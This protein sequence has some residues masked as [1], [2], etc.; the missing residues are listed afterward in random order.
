MAQNKILIFEK[1]QKPKAILEKVLKK[2][3]DLDFAD[4][5]DLDEKIEHNK[6]VL[7]VVDYQDNG[8]TLLKKIKLKEPALKVLVLSKEQN[9]AEVIMT[10]KMGGTYFLSKPLSEDALR[11][12]VHQILE[13][14]TFEMLDVSGDYPWYLS[15]HTKVEELLKMAKNVALHSMDVIL[16]GEQGTGKEALANFIHQNGPS[17]SRQFASLNL[18]YF[19]GEAIETHFWASLREIYQEYDNNA[20]GQKEPIYS[21]LFVQGIE[22][23]DV[24]FRMS[25]IEWLKQKRVEAE[26]KY[27]MPIRIVLAVNSP[28]VLKEIK[29]EALKSFVW[30][31]LLPLRERREDIPLFVDHLI[32]KYDMQFNKNIKGFTLDALKKLMLYSWPGNLREL[33]LMI[34]VVLSRIPENATQISSGDL[35]ITFSFLEEIIPVKKFS[36]VVPLA[37][38]SEEYESKLLK[39][40]YE[41]KEFDTNGVA[42]FLSDSP[43]EIDD[44]MIKYG[45]VYAE[46]SHAS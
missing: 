13:G 35:P 34:K 8:A 16:C 2:D 27:Q 31:D 6:Y 43:E 33:L 41:K 28:Q 3:F 23:Q 10:I 38:S 20:S 42:E 19:R 40:L 46:R 24:Y 17:R 30:L 25:L 21:T 26:G 12:T 14:M 39:Y 18:G 9:L 4:I 32:Q 5:E 1:D 15:T 37:E 29:E 7:A 11:E 22:T 36:A 44:K 45:I